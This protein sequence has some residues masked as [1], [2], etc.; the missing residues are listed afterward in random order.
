MKKNRFCLLKKPISP[1]LFLLLFLAAGILSANVTFA[2]N[3]AE[4]WNLDELKKVPSAQWTEP[5]EKEGDILS[6]KVWYAGEEF[7]GKETRTFAFFARPKGDGPFPGI[8]LVHGGGGTAFREWTEL[9]AREGYAALAMDLAG[10][11]V[12]DDGKRIPLPDGGPGQSDAEKFQ[13]FTPENYRK[14]WSWHAIANIMRAHSLLASLP[15]VD[16]SRTAATGISW[17]GYL[18]SM[19]A[20]IDDRFKVV[21]PVYGCGDLAK[22][23]IWTERLEQLPW[24]GMVTWQNFFDP[25]QYV[26]NA[27]CRV[28]FLAGTDDFAYPLDIHYSTFSRVPHADVRLQVHMPHGHAA[29]WNPREIA[30]YVN[31]VLKGTP[32]LPAL[33]KISWNRQP[34]GSI[35]VSAPIKTNPE[36]AVSAKLHYSTD[37]GGYEN[38]KWKIRQWDSLPAKVDL[39]SKT[40]SANIPEALAAQYPLRVFLEAQ[41]HDGLTI[42][43]HYVLCKPLPKPDFKPVP[44]D[45]ILL[46]G[47]N[48]DGKL[49]NRFIDKNGKPA[50]WKVE[51]DE[52]ISTAENPSNHI[53][54]DCDFRDAI[55]HAEFK[56]PEK[57]S[58]NS[59]LYVH[60]LY[61]MQI[62]NSAN[63]RDVNILEAGAFYRF[64]PPRTTAGL[65]GGTWQ[66]YDIIYRAP[67]RDESG[68]IIEKG[69]MT[70]WLNGILV[71]DKVEFEEARSQWHPMRRQNTNL[72][73]EKWEI[74]KKTGYA[75]LFLQDHGEPTRFRNIWIKPIE[76]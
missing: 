12:A 49:V 72:I 48:A 1:F 11:E 19:I 3:P 42:T 30:A 74:Q 67:R 2:R 57:G 20:G 73:R 46:F 9:W 58:G 33:G 23:S 54:S 37:V 70:A 63:A 45:G 29:G 59:G 69:Q 32:E 39:P 7:N 75:P 56:L 24:P 43:S 50:N 60:G 4:V 64:F 41:T 38:S 51:N 40:I 44:K 6:Q 22:N 27:K 8:I 25:I 10:N 76:E 47:R 13:S 5:V 18:T 16:A 61:E 34:D 55:I 65:S 28:F 14:M 68:K 53:H 35:T 62:L 26:G 71:Q 31:S 15:C 52:L 66:S 17:G 36:A 21:V